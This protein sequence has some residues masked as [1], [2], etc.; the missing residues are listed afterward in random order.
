MPNC[1]HCGVGL[2]LVVD[3]FCPECREE[4]AYTPEAQT[5]QDGPEESP[6]LLPDQDEAGESL[7]GSVEAAIGAAGRVAHWI[8]AACALL[9]FASFEVAAGQ[10][11]LAGNMEAAVVIALCGCTWA[12]WA[13]SQYRNTRPTLTVTGRGKTV[14]RAAR[15]E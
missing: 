6:K 4:L 7:A 8:L 2:P 1:P 12:V 3:A 13:R 15:V 10:A 9:V 11:A 14:E 5:R